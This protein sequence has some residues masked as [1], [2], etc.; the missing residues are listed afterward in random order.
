[1][2]CNSLFEYAVQKLHLSRE[3]ANIYNKIAKKALSKTAIR[4]RP[5]VKTNQNNKKAAEEIKILGTMKSVGA[6]RNLKKN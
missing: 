6:A 2:N 5:I 4:E 3:V 1:M